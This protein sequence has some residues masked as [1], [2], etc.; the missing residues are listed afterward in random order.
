MGFFNRKTTR[1]A[2]AEVEDLPTRVDNAIN[3]LI[4]TP[5]TTRAAVTVDSALGLATVW[6]CIQLLSNS[7]GILP[8]H[9][10]RRGNNGRE[11]VMRHPA[12]TLLS[13]PS[14]YWNAFD[15]KQ[16]LMVC[17]LTSGNGYAR[18]HRG[19]Y[20]N[21]LSV[22]YLYPYDVRPFLD[23]RSGHL[24]YDVKGEILDPYDII[25]IKGLGTN[26]IMGKSPIA[27]HR[28][29]LALTLE[30]QQYGESFFSRGGNVESVFEYPGALKKEAYDRLKKDLRKQMSGMQN[31]HTPLVLEGGMKY[32]R[33]NI[34]LEDAQFIQ[35]RKY[36]RSEI[37]AIFGV[38][39]H[40]IGDLDKA[41]YNNTELMGIE[42]VTYTLMP[43]LVKIQAEFA[44]KLLAEDEKEKL[45]FAFQTNGL[46]RGDAKSRSEFYKN[47][48]MIGAMN[49]NEIRE[50]EDMNTY[51]DGD[52]YFV[53]LN[54]TT[55]E[56]AGENND[57]NE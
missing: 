50:L 16:W 14:E 1:A 21:P 55:A 35:T 40:M 28:D 13:S 39:P 2:A 4:T 24:F 33:I 3:E 56:K 41:T 38:P 17:A 47:M 53:Q 8:L 57:N 19:E 6:A 29:N 54:M 9:L 18:I 49:A 11:R 32:N 25:H 12:L 44:R 37:A 34:P 45:Y 27:Q 10:Y 51:P 5:D 15:F 22:S 7:I 52:K 20:Y 30:S 43:W 23:E 42:Y 48:S 36:Q 46:M 26:P 31:A